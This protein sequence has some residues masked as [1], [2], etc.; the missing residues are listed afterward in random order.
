MGRRGMDSFE[1]I[2]KKQMD[3]VDQRIAQIE[4]KFDTRAASATNPVAAKMAKLK[5]E[6]AIL[7][8]EARAI[9]N[10]FQTRLKQQSFRQLR[11]DIAASE[12]RYQDLLA[13]PPPKPRSKFEGL[14]RQ[15]R[16]AW[17]DDLRA[18][19]GFG[20]KLKSQLPDAFE[21][22]AGPTRQIEDKLGKINELA[23]QQANLKKVAEGENQVTQAR[24]KGNAVRNKVR[25][26]EDKIEQ[27]QVN[28]ARTT[29]RGQK[30]EEE[31]TTAI[32]KQA[33][34]QKK[35][36]TVEKQFKTRQA[37]QKTALDLEKQL[38]TATQNRAKASQELTKWQKAQQKQVDRYGPNNIR[39]D[40]SKPGGA[41]DRSTK[42]LKEADQKVA[43]I[44]N[45]LQKSGR[46]A[47][48]SKPLNNAKQAFKGVKAEADAL[49]Q[50]LDRNNGRLAQGNQILGKRKRAQALDQMKGQMKGAALRGA[51]ASA[52]LIPGISPLAVGGFAGAAGGG[53]MVGGAVGVAVAA[54]VQGTVALG[55]FIRQSTIAAA[56]MKKMEL[57]LTA[58]VS[59]NLEYNEAL[60]SIDEISNSLLIPQAQVTKSFTR[61]QAAASASGFE[62]NDVKDMMK[63]F[64]AALVATEG[65]TRNFNG[66]MLAL[67]QV[68]GKGKAA[69]EE[70]RGQIGERLSVVIPELAA[71]MGVTTKELDKLFEQGKVTVQNI[72]DLGEHLEKKYGESAANIIKSTMNAGERLKFAMTELQLAIGPIFTDIGAG[73]QD[74]GTRIVNAITP[75]VN[76]LA[77]LLGLTETAMRQELKGLRNKDI[78]FDARHKIDNIYEKT[79][80]PK[81]KLDKAAGMNNPGKGMAFLRKYMQS[82]GKENLGGINRLDL[83]F[84]ESDLKRNKEIKQLEE[85]LNV[86][87]T[88]TKGKKTGGG[89]DQG[90]IQRLANAK[91][92]VDQLKIEKKFLEDRFN[93]GEEEADLNRRIAEARIQYGDENIE[94]IEKEI[95]GN[96]KLRKELEGRVNLEQDLKEALKERAT[97]LKDLQNPINQLKTITEAFEDSF[98]N[99]IREVVRGTKSIGD[100]VASMLNRIADAFIQNA[101]DMAAAAASNALMKFIGKSL[102]SGID[103]GGATPT[104]TVTSSGG[105]STTFYTGGSGT[106]DYAKGGYVN[107]PTNAIIGE[108]GEGEYIIPESKLASS[109]SRFQAGHRGNSVVPNGRDGGGASG[110]GSGEVTVN[111][112]GPTLNFNGDEYVPRS[113]VPQILIVQ[114]WPEQQR[115]ELTQ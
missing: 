109:L 59:S 29:A 41:I 35:L 63:G 83:V 102:F 115:V 37:N 74:L 6:R 32:E 55:N 50:A 108:G 79:W 17:V 72:V 20:N 97:A 4:R 96:E 105:S 107:R 106:L 26:L 30:L 86:I 23:R 60:K 111:Y 24:V 33:A 11:R 47:D 39:R 93:F 13:S 46:A 5:D 70:L 12:G 7:G 8:N 80:I 71:S 88:G 91:K 62:V 53:D 64:S 42:A 87:T 25:T 58:V 44:N 89:D 104:H 49:G 34:A 73:F 14:T 85:R 100:A 9:Q 31:R 95:R 69:A 65:D 67:G 54:A 27:S 66:V 112:T 103:T 3:Y 1:R 40:F 19:R 98:S 18:E 38:A 110:G 94:M 15:T 114:R 78:A 113:A 16:K 92:Y 75:A 43:E 45:K 2:T 99:A 56:E 52:A 81:E 101:A 68:M 61:L 36:N 28:V 76:K 21:A 48:W 90:T 57:A 82:R 22:G 51:G 84:L 10:D 77:E